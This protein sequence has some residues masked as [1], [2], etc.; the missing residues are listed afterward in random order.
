MNAAGIETSVIRR[1]TRLYREIE[2]IVSR[3]ENGILPVYSHRLDTAH[4]REIIGILNE[5]FW[6]IERHDEDDRRYQEADNDVER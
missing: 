3:I 6:A 5:G 1:G 4:V 2:R